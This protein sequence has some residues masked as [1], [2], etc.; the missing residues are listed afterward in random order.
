M[1]TARQQAA[2]RGGRRRARPTGEGSARI[3]AAIRE[4]QR[5]LAAAA[6][7]DSAGME[8][9]HRGRVAARRLR[10]M[11][12][13]FRPLLEPR[14]ARLYRVD[15]RSFARSLAAV[16]EADVRRELLVALAGRD[17]ALP[18]AERRRLEALLEDAGIAARD[19][20]DRHR[21][22]PGWLA[23]RKALE[24]HAAGK[25]L[26]AVRGA[27]LGDVLGLVERAWRRPLRM[28][29]AH[30]RS[31]TELHELRLA[32][33]HCRYALEP[34]AYVAP[35]AADRLARRLR[36]TQDCIGEHRDT[37]LAE[38][39]VRSNERLLGRELSD[40]L[41]ADLVGRE[42]LLR[43]RAARRCERVLEAWRAWRR[44]TRKLRTEP[45]TGRR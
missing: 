5:L 45:S 4:Q 37:L 10:S 1:T 35:E 6:A 42:R 16:R 34:V 15:L 39:W 11:L 8:D 17:D 24:R 30:P 18:V 23:L 13:T 12:K 27:T 19:T 2:A 3:E 38:H 41:A 28:L 22:E 40:R 44:A 36:A 7:S 32:F 43:R 29:A 14:R 25:A 9:V 31:T 33:K 26:L 21:A 20:M